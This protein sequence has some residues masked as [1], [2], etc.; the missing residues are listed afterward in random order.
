MHPSVVPEAETGRGGKQFVDGHAAKLFLGFCDRPR[1]VDPKR[2]AVSQRRAEEAKSAGDLKRAVRLYSDALRDVPYNA[3]LYFL[4]GSALLEA[5]Q[6]QDG[7]KDF[8]AGPPVGPRQSDP[9][10]PYAHSE[11]LRGAKRQTS[12]LVDTLDPLLRASLYSA[13]I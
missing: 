11:C 12:V 9:D 13:H 7:A 1:R 10:L 8:V 4:R 5:K 6:P 2:A 3:A